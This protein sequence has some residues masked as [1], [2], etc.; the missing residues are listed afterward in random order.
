MAKFNFASLGPWSKGMFVGVKASDIPNDG[1]FDALNVDVLPEGSVVSAPW[2]LKIDSSIAHSLF[3]CNDR[4]YGVVDGQV[5]EITEFGFLGFGSTEASRLAWTEI[6]GVPYFTDGFG[7]FRLDGSIARLQANADVDDLDDRVVDMPG[8]RYITYWNGRIVVAKGSELLFSQ[9]LRYGAH[10]LLTDYIELGEDV[11]WL[12][13][14][15]TG[16]FVGLPDRVLFLDG[17][18]PLEMRIRVVAGQSAP[19]ACLVIDGEI[20]GKPSVGRFVVFF[21]SSGF[22]LG[23]GQGMVAYPQVAQVRNLPLYEGMIVR[24]GYRLFFIRRL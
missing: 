8:G 5:G 18:T 17:V 15:E 22:A 10:N 12:A 14:L 11:T 16:L 19:G 23:D 24:D 3:V 4:V 21:T 1:L 2:W 6:A 20:I 7:V 9:P 13:G